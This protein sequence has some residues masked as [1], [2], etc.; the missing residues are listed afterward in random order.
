MALERRTEEFEVID[1]GEV[2]VVNKVKVRWD[3][4]ARQRFGNRLR[5]LRKHKSSGENKI[6]QKTMAELSGISA[7]YIA[8]LEA[9]YRNPPRGEKLNRLAD[10][11]GTSADEL[12]HVAPGLNVSISND[13]I[14]EIDW[15]F[16]A[17][18]N[19]PHYAFFAELKL[20]LATKF[21]IV[22]I[23]E[24]LHE[25]QLLTTDEKAILA[26][27][28]VE[29]GQQRKSPDEY[30]L[31]NFSQNLLTLVKQYSDGNVIPTQKVVQAFFDAMCSST[32]APRSR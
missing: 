17:V 11:Y 15:A 23:Y 22:Q 13:I 32:D 9:G 31:T 28:I 5:S 8:A 29:E 18:V 2:D 24:L 20:P 27:T 19:D 25:R 26:A 14:A 3:D 1:V 4:A 10:A 7:G 16:K 30:R 6:T 21:N 12:L